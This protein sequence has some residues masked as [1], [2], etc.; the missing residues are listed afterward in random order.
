[1]IFG[2]MI[3]LY[4]SIYILDY[5]GDSWRRIDFGRYYLVVGFLGH[6]FW[7]ES[8]RHCFVNDPG[9]RGLDPSK[10]RI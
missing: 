9:K 5:F 10:I 7:R 1:M 6:I 8:W 3:C 2:M 4:Y